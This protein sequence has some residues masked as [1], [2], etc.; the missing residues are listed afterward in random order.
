MS[1]QPPYRLCWR[2]RLA[3]RLTRVSLRL[4]TRRY[5]D[6]VTEPI[7]Q[8][9]EAP[10]LPE[11]YQPRDGDVVVVP[12]TPGRDQITLEHMNISG[13]D[14]EGR[15]LCAGSDMSYDMYPEDR[16]RAV[17]V[18]RRTDDLPPCFAGRHDFTAT[19]EAWAAK[20]GRLVCA[21]GE[22][23]LTTDATALAIAQGALV[24]WE[25]GGPLVDPEQDL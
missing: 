24:R 2:D 3:Y 11:N 22:Q 19:E 21:C 7:F 5:R 9:H 16:D 23:S 25:A 20:G 10:G 13:C 14:G 4:A 8:A 15:W 18:Y 12:A 6:F 1:R 17:L